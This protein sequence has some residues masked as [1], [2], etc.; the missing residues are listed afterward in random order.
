VP[1]K[2]FTSHSQIR[3][4]VMAITSRGRAKC[5]VRLFVLARGRYLTSLQS[6]RAL[7]PKFASEAAARVCELRNR[8]TS[9]LLE[10]DLS[11][12]RYPL[13]GIMLYGG[14]WLTR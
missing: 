5:A 8:D 11:E 10:H 7:I 9:L 2:R 3:H 12:N 14:L 13:F 1:V 6:R 4:F